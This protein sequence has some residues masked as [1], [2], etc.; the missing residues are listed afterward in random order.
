M[1]LPIS[2]FE[3][4][5]KH[6]FFALI[7]LILV[8][9]VWFLIVT[10]LERDKADLF[11]ARLYQIVFHFTGKPQ[12]ERRFI[13]NDVRGRINRSRKAIHRGRGKPQKAVDVEW[14]ADT[15]PHSFDLNDG[16]FVVRLDPARDQTDNI[17]AMTEVVVKRTCLTGVRHLTPPG[18]ELA[19]DFTMIKKLLAASAQTNILDRFFSEHYR[20]LEAQDTEFRKWNTRVAPI[21]E[22]GLFE[23]LLMV[24]LNDFA[25]EVIGLPPRPYMVDEIERMV[26]WVFGI[27]TKKEGKDVPLEYLRPHVRVA[28]VLV[29]KT[30]KMLSEGIGPYQRAA[31]INLF[32]R[33][34]HTLYL[35]TWD[36]MHLSLRRGGGAKRYLRLCKALQ[37]CLATQS[38]VY[39]D[40]R[41]IYSYVDPNGYSRQ[42]EISRFINTNASV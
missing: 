32:E 25:R 36:K 24:E 30:D 29:A 37:S 9:T 18:L 5:A 28:A 11:R 19:I 1:S 14:V 4:A 8:L 26:E 27:A 38:G 15:R 41:E 3:F 7:I 10:L 31:E 34:V 42:G 23:R 12:H 39:L 16:E 35:I 17:I 13:E 40:F 33:K 20:P 21:D 22:Q 2:I 6:G